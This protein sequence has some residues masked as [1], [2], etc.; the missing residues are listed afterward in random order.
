MPHRSVK[1]TWG[2]DS[3]FGSPAIHTGLPAYPQAR[4]RL[5]AK[6]P[7]RPLPNGPLG[8]WLERPPSPR[9]WYGIGAVVFS[10]PAPRRSGV[11]PAPSIPAGRPFSAASDG[12]V[13]GSLRAWGLVPETKLGAPRSWYRVGPQKD[14]RAHGQPL[15]YPVAN[16]R[17]LPTSVHARLG[18][19]SFM[20]SAGTDRTLA[21]TWRLLCHRKNAN[22][23]PRRRQIAFLDLVDHSGCWQSIDLRIC[24]I[25]D[26]RRWINLITRGFLDHRILN[27][28]ANL[29]GPVEGVLHV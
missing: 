1:T 7:A 9:A 6:R 11:A 2:V 12:V 14:R 10:Q 16:D 27:G 22:A 4:Q 20:T 28:T 15:R 19:V 26:G 25:R 8:R 23:R 13:R 3:H 5:A 29:E 21:R 17:F 24:A 18:R